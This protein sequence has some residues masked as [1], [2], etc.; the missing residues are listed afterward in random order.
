MDR[1]STSIKIKVIDVSYQLA[2]IRYPNARGY[3]GLMKKIALDEFG[4][5]LT[6]NRHS[7]WNHGIVKDDKKL[8]MFLLSYGETK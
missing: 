4:V 6:K 8:M 2:W 5:G 7:Y 1:V 3:Q